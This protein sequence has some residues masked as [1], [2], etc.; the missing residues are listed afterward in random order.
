MDT[1]PK[2]RQNA[3]VVQEMSDEVLVYDLDTNKAHCLNSS[4]ALVW[5]SC[6][7][8][9]SVADIVL[10]FE[11]SGAGEVSED[12]VWLAIDQLNENRLLEEDVTPRFSGQSRRQ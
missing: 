8:T 7:G 2:A 6:D 1:N 10:E 5:R 3:L 12:F 4:A 11:R 9:R